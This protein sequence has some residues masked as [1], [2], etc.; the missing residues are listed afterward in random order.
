MQPS[1]LHPLF[2]SILAPMR[3]AEPR[4]PRFL[5]YYHHCGTEWTDIWDST[6]NDRCPVCR[7]E[8]EPHHSE[9]ISS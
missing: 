4:E 3:P 9:E 5:N 8:I 7:A 6:C 1:A 2:V